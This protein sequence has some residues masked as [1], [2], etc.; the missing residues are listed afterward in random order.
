MLHSNLTVGF[1]HSFTF[2]R[3]LDT[4]DVDGQ[5]TILREDDPAY[6][7]WARGTVT[8]SLAT[9]VFATHTTRGV[10]DEPVPIGRSEFIR[11]LSLMTLM[12]LLLTL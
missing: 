5:D 4:L 2:R 12:A 11:L 10:T 3:L 6:F 9:P 7:I 1:K 8:G